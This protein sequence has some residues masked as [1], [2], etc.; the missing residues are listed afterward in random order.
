MIQSRVK[1]AGIGIEYRFN[2]DM[3][4][5]IWFLT[6]DPGY[7]PAIVLEIDGLSY[8]RSSVAFPIAVVKAAREFAYFHSRKE[9]REYPSHDKLHRP[10]NPDGSYKKKAAKR[11]KT[12]LVLENGKVVPKR[13]K[14]WD[15]SR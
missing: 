8:K 13:T 7:K 6:E 14:T 10:V 4:G 15:L 12:R 3:F 11:V 1:T 2:R 9:I 5:N